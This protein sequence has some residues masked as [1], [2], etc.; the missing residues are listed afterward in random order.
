[1]YCS[2]MCLHAPLEAGLKPGMMSGADWLGQMSTVTLMSILC[3]PILATHSPAEL[4]FSPVVTTDSTNATTTTIGQGKGI[5]QEQSSG[6]VR[7]SCSFRSVHGRSAHDIKHRYVNKTT[8]CICHVC[9]VRA[10]MQVQ[11]LYYFSTGIQ[12]K[13]FVL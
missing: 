9:T 8:H 12:N 1:M 5:K 4:W 6:L 10:C 7:T 3:V 2:C 13:E 11:G